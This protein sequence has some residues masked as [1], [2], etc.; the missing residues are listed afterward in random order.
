[1]TSAS[2]GCSL[3]RI[4]PRFVRISLTLRPQTELS[5]LGAD[6]EHFARLDVPDVGCANQ[7]HRARFRRDH[8]GIVETSERE[9]PEPVTIA[10]GNA[11]VGG[12][13]TALL[14]SRVI[15]AA[16][17]APWCC[18]TD[19]TTASTGFGAFDRA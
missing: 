15:K 18:E 19:S 11:A 13:R 16:E 7:I 5:A 2:T 14:R 3:A 8:G 9:R 4:R 1:M 12:S 10:G 17:N 6:H